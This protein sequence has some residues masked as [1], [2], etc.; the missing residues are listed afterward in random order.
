MSDTT[1]SLTKLAKPG[2]FS[3][4]TFVRGSKRSDSRECIDNWRLA[5]DKLVR[6]GGTAPFPFFVFLVP[7]GRAHGS[8]AVKDWLARPTVK[9]RLDAL[10]GGHQLWFKDRKIERPFPGGPFVLLHTLSHLLIQSLAMRCGYP[11]SSIR[12]RIYNMLMAM[13]SASE[14]CSIREP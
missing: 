7:S 2:T 13:G 9:Q 8:E 10:A 3:C 1:D 5:N 6:E 11:A 4:Q 14:S 12:E